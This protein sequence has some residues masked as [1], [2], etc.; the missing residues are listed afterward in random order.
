MSQ[1]IFSI[2]IIS[3]I[4]ALFALLLELADAFIANYGECRISINREKELVVQGGNSLLFSLM[5]EGIFIPS[6]CGGKGTCAY[7]KVKVLEGGGPILPTETPYLTEEEQ[8]K[9]V[10]LSCQVK[11]R[12]DL[13]IELPAELFLIEEFKVKVDRIVDLTPFIKG[14]TLGILSPEE[15]ISFKPGQYIQLEIPKY[16]L[17]KEPEYRAFSMASSS[18][19]PQSVELYIGLV[20][21]GLVS[22][23][24]HEYLKEGEELIMRGP[25]GDFYFRDSERDILLV[26][27]GTGLAPILSIL[28]HIRS[29]QIQRKTTLFFGTRIREDMYCVEELKEMEKQLP[30][31]TFIPTLSRE[32]ESSQW[33]GKRGRVTDLIEDLVPEGADYDVYICGNSDMVDSCM[34][35]LLEKGIP[36]DQIYFDKFS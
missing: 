28:R 16:K 27:T 30:A 4:G 25:F 5:E 22:T 34:D 9:N 23:Y 15:G 19:G 7:C 36:E 6:A 13:V 31:F 35:R 1:L 20:E 18:K 3:G 29:E 11:V 14:V 33:E 8:A 17:S 10:R 2:L 24:V 32:A 21:K 26:A 12:N